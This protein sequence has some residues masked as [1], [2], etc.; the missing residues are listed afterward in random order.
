MSAAENAT[1]NELKQSTLLQ[2]IRALKGNSLLFRHPPNHRRMLQFSAS[3][4]PEMTLEVWWGVF[5]GP[6]VVYSDISSFIVTL[7][8]VLLITG[9]HTIQQQNVNSKLCFIWTCRNTTKSFVFNSLH[10]CFWNSVHD[11]KIHILTNFAAMFLFYISPTRRHNSTEQ[12]GT[13]W[14]WQNTVQLVDHWLN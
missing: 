4:P 7:V 5:F 11:K 2:Q 10:G 13:Y 8:V 9:N 12:F 3:W 1:K 14:Q 6:L